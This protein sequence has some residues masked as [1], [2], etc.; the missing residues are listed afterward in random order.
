MNVLKKYRNVFFEKIGRYRISR[1][2][3][4]SMAIGFIWDFA[5]LMSNSYAFNGYHTLLC[6]LFGVIV[7]RLLPWGKSRRQEVLKTAMKKIAELKSENE[8]LIHAIKKQNEVIKEQNSCLEKCIE[9]KKQE[10][11]EDKKEN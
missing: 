5:D 1:I 2:F 6:F 4:I 9:I 7:E 10:T 8:E 11:R 3:I